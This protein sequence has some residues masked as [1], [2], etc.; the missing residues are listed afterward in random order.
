[1]RNGVENEINFCQVLDQG[2][3]QVDINIEVRTCQPP[4][5]GRFGPSSVSNSHGNAVETSSAQ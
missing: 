1:M 2:K 4:G 5:T 3:R